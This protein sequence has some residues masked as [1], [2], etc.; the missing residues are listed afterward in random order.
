[1][2]GTDGAQG[3]GLLPALSAA[4][5]V[6]VRASSRRDKVEAWRAAGTDAVVADLTD[7]GAVVAAAGDSG[8]AAV[9]GH[10][11]L[12]LGPR[13]GR[14]VESYRALRASGLPVAVNTGTPVPP[15]QAPDPQDARATAGA[16]RDAGAVVLTPTAYLENHAAPWGLPRLARGELIYPRPA[17]DVIA[18]VAAADLGR[19]V[20]AALGQGRGG[21]LLAL[22]GPRALTFTDLAAEISAGLGRVLTFVRV[23]PAEYGDAL[24]P[25]LGDAAAAGVQGAYAAMP[26]TPNPAFDPPGAAQA[27]RDLG[28]VP[29][30]ARE[31][32]AATLRPRLAAAVA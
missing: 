4:G 9:A 19:A 28:V 14:A 24:R 22:A 2:F 16:L 5:A 7:P 29:A 13:A 8:A 10:L 27:W 15:P 23:T 32:A 18:W 20:I 3:S 25:Y 6:P 17:G 31:W 12:A 30:S 21:E 11:P 26:E 1:V